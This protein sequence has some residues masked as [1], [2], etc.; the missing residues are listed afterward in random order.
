M[1][2]IFTAVSSADPTDC[3]DGKIEVFDCSNMELVLFM[4]VDQLGGARGVWVNNVWGW[5]DPETGRDCA[6]VSRRDGAA[7]VDVTNAAQP[8]LVGSLAESRLYCLG[9]SRRPWDACGVSG[10]AVTFTEDEHYNQIHSAHNV[11]ADTDSGCLYIVG[12]SG[13]R[14]TCSSG[15]HM[16]DARNPKQ[17]TFAGCYTD[18]TSVRGYTHDAQCVIY[19]GPDAC[20]QGH[21]ICVGSNE[22]EINIADVTDKSSPVPIGRKSYP[23]VAY[24]HQGWFDEQHQYF[25]MGDK[26][27]KIQ[28]S[29]AGTRTIVWD[30]SKLDDSVVVKEYIGQATDHNLFIKD[31][32]VYMSN[33][34]SGLRVVDISDRKNS[35]EVAFFNSAPVG[36]NEAGTSAMASGAWSNYPFFKSG[37]VVFTSVREGLFI[38]RVKPTS[39]VP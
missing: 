9:R 31:D 39:L 28:G 25:Y 7:F 5:T 19:H 14:E 22:A 4:S 30:L 21:Q 29:V 37:L 36:D 10:P 13:G 33:Y 16:V 32:Q 6:L 11:V 27:D 12:A 2:E 15:L 3:T 8:R 26:A 35:Q 17:P 20:Y 38:V 34:G 1:G 18:N 23:N 24:A